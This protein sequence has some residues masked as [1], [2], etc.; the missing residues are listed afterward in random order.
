M[1]WLAEKFYIPVFL[2]AVSV[3]VGGS[4]AIFVIENES[5]VLI[6]YGL[7]V[8]GGAFLIAAIILGV[9]SMFRRDAGALEIAEDV[10][11]R[12]TRLRHIKQTEPASLVSNVLHQENSV[13]ARQDM[14]AKRVK[15]AHKSGKLKS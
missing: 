13:T 14:R 1:F 5:R 8:A 3:V 11:A 9:K 4:G 12:R 6:G 2:L 7:I 15:A 10:I